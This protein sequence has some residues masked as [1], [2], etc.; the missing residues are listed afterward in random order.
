MNL[1]GFISFHPL[2]L[3]HELLGKRRLHEKGRARRRLVQNRSTH[4][5]LSFSPDRNDVP[6]FPVGDGGIRPNDPFRESLQVL[7]EGLDDAG[8]RPPKV[9]PNS[10]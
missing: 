8:V 3:I 4:V 1:P 2:Q 6:T 7:L 9:R 10:P 5:P